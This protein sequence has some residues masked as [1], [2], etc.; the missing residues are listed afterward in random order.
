VWCGQAPDPAALAPC[1]LFAAAIVAWAIAA[2][3]ALVFA[4]DEREQVAME[5][6]L[7]IGLIACTL[8]V[9]LHIAPPAIAALLAIAMAAHAL[10]IAALVAA[11]AFRHPPARPAATGT[12]FGRTQI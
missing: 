3:G 7:V 9:V 1:C 10:L 4:A 12:A 11:D 5:D 6:V 8:I 2:L